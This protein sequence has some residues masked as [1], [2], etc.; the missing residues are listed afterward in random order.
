MKYFIIYGDKKTQ[1]INKIHINN[2]VIKK[3][4]K[5]FKYKKFNNHDRCFFCGKVLKKD[6]K[7]SVCK[8]LEYNDPV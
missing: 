8:N 6:E 7:N 5:I 1:L 4:S 2:Y 3:I